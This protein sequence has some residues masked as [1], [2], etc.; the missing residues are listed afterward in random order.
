MKDLIVLT[1]DKSMKLVVESLLART[2]YLRLR[3]ITF[4]A[5]PHPEND[6]GV[7]L[8]AHSFLRSQL[9]NYGYAV[10]VCDRCG[11]GKETKSRE[12]LEKRIE[13]GLQSNGWE[14]RSAAVVIDPELENWMWGDWGTSSNALRWTN[15]RSL[16]EWLIQEDLL[17]ATHAK[18]HDPKRALERSAQCAGKRWSS[19][20][21][22]QIATEA[23]VEGCTDPAFLKLRS[24]LQ[25]WFPLE[26]TV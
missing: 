13:D 2:V 5:I 21:H 7:R 11:S 20:I 23:R 25:G 14:N 6:P 12:V 10:A 22:Q 17:N 4:D 24:V 1:A 16:R 8:R 15:A 9:R 19:S 3:S 18:P 26:V